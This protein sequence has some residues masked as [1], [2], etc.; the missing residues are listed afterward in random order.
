MTHADPDDFATIDEIIAR[1]R[2]VLDPAHHTWAAAGAGEGVTALRNTAALNRLALVPRV[3]RN[4]E[5][6]DPSS[7]FVGV[8]LG[9][10]VFLA[11][12]AALALFDPA[13]AV[14]AGTAA[15]GVG[16]GLMCSALTLCPWEEVAATAP[17]RQMFQLYV[18]GDR[19][20]TTDV[21]ARV[22]DAGYAAFCV[23]VDTPVIG[24]RDRSL[25]E[26]YVWNYPDGGPPNFRDIGWDTSHRT[27]YSLGDLEWLCD[28]SEL[29]VVAKGIMTAD[30][31]TAAVEA[32]VAGIYV[33]NH[34]GRQ[35][36][37]GISTIEVLSEI[38]DAVG[39][40]VDVAIDGGFTR[41]AEICAA[42]ALGADAVGIGRL[43]CWG[44]AAGGTSGLTRVLEI[45][46]E[47]ITTTMANLGCRTV[48]DLTPGHVRWSFA[49]P[50]R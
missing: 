30:D 1:A 13:D 15:A 18:F 4:V 42:L 41:G 5:G 12:V 43:Q 47:E 34:G 9:F 20:W 10:G 49:T 16:T 50:V 44:L 33:S 29:P 37:H 23:T 36:D 48:A 25:E 21:L 27:R 3:L 39:D 19:G 2:K 46:R 6:V 17:G 38:V 32:G 14:A 31:A 45:L 35:V 7:S 24:R 8:P 40:E 11:P 28:T 26:R 22:H